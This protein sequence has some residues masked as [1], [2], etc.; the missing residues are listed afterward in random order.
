[1]ATFQNIIDDARVDLQDSVGTRYTT[2][3]LIGYANDGVREMFRIR[4]DFRLG[5]YGVVVPTYVVGDTL[6][7]PDN[8]RM[9]LTNYLIFRAE[10]RDDEYAV[11]GRATL[12]LARFEKEL[13]T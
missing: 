7:I 1:M 3:Q 8:Y 6:P 10:V 4:P 13:K 9:L 12:F 11:N 5:S 2:A